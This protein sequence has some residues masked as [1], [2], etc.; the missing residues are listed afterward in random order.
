MY[1]GNLGQKSALLILKTTYLKSAAAAAPVGTN[2]VVVTVVA[3]VPPTGRKL[4]H[5]FRRTPIH[6]APD[7]LLY[8]VLLYETSH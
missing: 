6:S 2:V 1:P 3:Q 5:L 4:S 8:I 7:P